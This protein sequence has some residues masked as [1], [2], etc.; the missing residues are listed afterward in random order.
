M[1]RAR[2]VPW[3]NRQIED[4]CRYA[5]GSHRPHLQLPSGAGPDAMATDKYTVWSPDVSRRRV[6]LIGWLERSIGPIVA[7]SASA[8]CLLLFLLRRTWIFAIAASPAAIAS[9]VGGCTADPAA[10]WLARRWATALR[11]DTAIDAWDCHPADRGAWDRAAEHGIAAIR[12][13]RTR[14][15]LI[16]ADQL[17]RAVTRERWE[18][19]QLCHELQRR[20][21]A[22][23]GPLSA[24]ART[25]I[26]DMTAVV[27]RRVRDLTTLHDHLRALN[28]ISPR[29]SPEHASHSTIFDQ[30]DRAIARGEAYR[31]AEDL[32]ERLGA[33]RDLLTE[34]PR[35]DIASE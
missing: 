8:A 3:L 16:D 29:A 22:G 4:G 23:N 21:S 13:A 32:N 9:C 25:A 18:I 6:V 14:P 2:L 19:A 20:Y 15:D 7:V 12:L 1:D 5:S 26:S 24:Q 34:T 31:P 35:P 10:A 17:T 28:A 11:R 33:L 30:R 27:Q